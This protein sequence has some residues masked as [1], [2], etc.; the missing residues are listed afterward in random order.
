MQCIQ[1]KMLLSISQPH[2]WKRRDSDK[3]RATE[4]D[5]GCF[6]LSVVEK[7]QEVEKG[8]GKRAPFRLT[9]DNISNAN[10]RISCI[11]IPS[12]DFTPGPIFSRTFGLKSHDWKEV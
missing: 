9:T 7:G 2:D 11:S 10:T 12:I 3:V 6:G 5:L 1:L 4:I 8:V